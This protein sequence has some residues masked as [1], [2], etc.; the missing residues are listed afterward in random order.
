MT[1]A[2]IQRE[3]ETRLYECAYLAHPHLTHEELEKVTQNTKKIIERHQGVISQEQAPFKRKLGYPIAKQREAYFGF[4]RFSMDP[5]KAY[6]ITKTLKLETPLLRFLILAVSPQQ[7]QEEQRQ[8]HRPAPETV[9]KLYRP[10]KEAPQ[11]IK[12]E[13]FEKKLEE[14]LGDEQRT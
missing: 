12:P 1:E 13:E 5:S 4:L 3:T 2:L 7:L 10:K 14:L 11:E 6:E 9:K 8:L